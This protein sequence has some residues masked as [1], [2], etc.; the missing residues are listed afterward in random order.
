[1]IET[2]SVGTGPARADAV[3][4]VG[5]LIDTQIIKSS[6][7]LLMSGRNTGRSCSLDSSPACDLGDVVPYQGSILVQLS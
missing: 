3:G 5:L 4:L 2:R 6:F 1:M 7:G